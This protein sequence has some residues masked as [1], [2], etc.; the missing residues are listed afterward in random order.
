MKSSFDHDNPS[1]R[2]TPEDRPERAAHRA[3]LEQVASL[4]TMASDPR[5]SH[6]DRLHAMDLLAM[7]ARLD[8]H[9]GAAGGRAESI[10]GGS[11]TKHAAGKHA[12]KKH[13]AKKHAA[14]KH[15]A[16]KHAAKHALERGGAKQIGAPREPRRLTGGASPAGRLGSGG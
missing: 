10:S 9:T 3:L 7:I 13:A 4:R 2:S 14:K 11:A 8:G 5:A 12:A 1:D 6:A 15:A 16:K